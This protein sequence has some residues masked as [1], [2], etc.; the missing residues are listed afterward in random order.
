[1][2]M[3][4]AI[5]DDHPLFRE[6]LKFYL[7][8]HHTVSSV[9]AYYDGEDCVDSIVTDGIPDLIFMDILMPRLNGIETSKWLKKNHPEIKIIGMSSLEDIK[10][11]EGMINAD[12]SS[13][14]LKDATAEEID[15]ALLETLKG[16]NYFSPKILILLAKKNVNRTIDSQMVIS[17]ISP[18]EMQVLKLI[19]SGY[20]REYISDKLGIA[21][22]TVDKHRENL[23]D[24]TGSDNLIQMMIF[25]L[26]NQLVTVE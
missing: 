2:K 18:R 1:M 10:Y 4:I 23:M 20:S 26:K 3:K 22:K 11:I 25:S 9:V 6:G 8:S 21:E 17:K 19:C 7:S 15:I 5:V 13:Y 16:R 24:K 12:V 14:L